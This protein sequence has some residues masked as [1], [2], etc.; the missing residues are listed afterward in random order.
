MK[1]DS[2]LLNKIFIHRYMECEPPTKL[3]IIYEQIISGSD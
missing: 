1:I 3:S 2:L